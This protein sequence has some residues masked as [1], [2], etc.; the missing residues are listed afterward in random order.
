MK[1]LYGP[2]SHRHD[3]EWHFILHSSK[4]NTKYILSS[5]NRKSTRYRLR[6]MKGEGQAKSVQ[7]FVHEN[8]ALRKGRWK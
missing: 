2:D 1:F 4:I 8:L 3:R 6:V 5:F 7:V